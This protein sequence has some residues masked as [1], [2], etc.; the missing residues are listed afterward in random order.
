MK[1]KK[2]FIKGN[3]KIKIISNDGKPYPIP[4]SWRPVLSKCDILVIIPDM[5]MYIYNSHLDNFRYGA[6]AMLKLLNHLSSLK[7]EM[8]LEDQTLNFTSL[9]IYT[10]RDFP[11]CMVQMPQQ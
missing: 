2:D 8:E 9:V 7:E 1:I 5:H 4:E 3:K 11:A 10:N 6:D